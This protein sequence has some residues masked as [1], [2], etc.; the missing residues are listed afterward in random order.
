MVVLRGA[1]FLMREVP[2][3]RQRAEQAAKALRH[4]GRGPLKKAAPLLHIPPAAE[5][6]GS[7][8]RV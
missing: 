1:R 8:F 2:H 5:E 7:G 3:L 4:V 6:P